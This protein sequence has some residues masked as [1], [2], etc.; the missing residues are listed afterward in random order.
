[1]Q[2]LPFKT[3]TLTLGAEIGYGEQEELVRLDECDDRLDVPGGDSVKVLREVTRPG[4]ANRVAIL[5]ARCEG[6]AD[7]TTPRA[8]VDS[9]DPKRMGF[10]GPHHLSQPLI[11]MGR[12]K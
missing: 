9:V 8:G 11:I 2:M 12:I 1:M 3:A 7:Q 10:A 4:A 6:D 5:L